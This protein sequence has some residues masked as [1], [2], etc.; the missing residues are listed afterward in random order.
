MAE[1]YFGTHLCKLATCLCW[2]QFQEQS[3]VNLDRFYSTMNGPPITVLVD[4]IVQHS[5]RQQITSVI[6]NNY[7]Q[8]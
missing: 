2:P 6:K 1:S 3:V 7:W 8:Q 4:Y 5:F